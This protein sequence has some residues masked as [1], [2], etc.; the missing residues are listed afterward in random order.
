MS[1]GA[2]YR[3]FMEVDKKKG[4]LKVHI[5][6]VNRNRWIEEIPLQQRTFNLI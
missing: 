5:Y 1:G 3:I 6:D 4:S 2:S